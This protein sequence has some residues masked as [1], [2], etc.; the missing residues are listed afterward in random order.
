[1]AQND[2]KWP[3][4]A[5]I[6]PKW[7]KMAQNG[8]RMTQSGPKMTQNGPQL[9]QM[10]QKWRPDLR[11]FSKSF[12]SQSLS[13]ERALSSEIGSQDPC[14]AHHAVAA[15]QHLMLLWFWLCQKNIESCHKPE[16]WKPRSVRWPTCP[17]SFSSLSFSPA[18]VFVFLFGNLYFSSIS[19]SALT[20]SLGLPFYQKH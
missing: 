1:M 19:S 16:S 7:P 17:L 8:P 13:L 9:P 4:V 6:W 10:A 2:P 11:T 20:F 15:W 18:F 5:Q 14:L 12:V 3:K